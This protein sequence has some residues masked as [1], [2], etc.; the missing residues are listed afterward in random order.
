MAAQNHTVD[1]EIYPTQFDVAVGGCFGPTFTVRLDED[2]LVYE[3]SSGAYSLG[4]AQS[5]RPTGEQWARFWDE[6]DVIGAWRWRP[7]YEKAGEEGAHWY[8]HISVNDHIV[9]SEGDG[10]FPG[11]DTGSG[12]SKEFERFLTALRELLGGV[13]LW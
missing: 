2:K 4:K 7:L 1:K 10:A 12:P 3:K 11:N 6:I 8:V 13:E 9:T 5:I